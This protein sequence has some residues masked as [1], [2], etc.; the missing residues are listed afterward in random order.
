MI[1]HIKLATE[2][3]GHLLI[4]SKL[5]DFLFLVVL[6]TEPSKHYTTEQALYY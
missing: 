5:C 6:G 3:S 1:I 4:Y 2:N